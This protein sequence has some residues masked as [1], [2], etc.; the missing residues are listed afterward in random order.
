MINLL[1]NDVKT[2]YRYARRNLGLR[3]WVVAFVVAF[4]GL[5]VI[6]TFGLLTLHQQTNHYQ[7]QITSS[8]NA[9]EKEKFSQT[10][11]QV[12]EISNNFKLAV[13]VL[14]KEVL[15]SEL[16]QHIAATIPPNTNLT[17]L[18]ITGDSGAIDISAVAKDYTSASQVQVN[19]ADPSNKIFSRADIVSI[20]CTGVSSSSTTYPCSV[21][22]RAL[23]AINNPFSFINSSGLTSTSKATP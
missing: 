21:T 20:S 17:G 4:V 15:F 22:I 14:G 16:I 3:R 11:A 9:F 7:A 19:L 18:N 10:Q 2:N 12:E 13:K 1:P 5:G 8:Q 6:A 23:F